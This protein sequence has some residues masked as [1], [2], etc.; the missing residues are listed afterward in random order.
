M[1]AE[2]AQEYFK[3]IGFDA[4]IKEKDIKGKEVEH[5]K[6]YAKFDGYEG[7]EP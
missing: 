7:G 6:E 4:V 1:T 2:Q 3:S 5:H